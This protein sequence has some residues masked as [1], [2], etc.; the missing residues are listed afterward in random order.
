V[1]LRTELGKLKLRGREGKKKIESRASAVKDDLE[2]A[3]SAYSLQH[4]ITSFDFWPTLHARKWSGRRAAGGIS[5]LEPLG[6]PSG[7][8]KG[9]F[10][11]QHEPTTTTTKHVFESKRK[12]SKFNSCQV[13]DEE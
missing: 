9:D 13:D 5:T 8:R 2:H 7:A 3:G 10:D 1:L 11:G 4:G 12:E 6:L